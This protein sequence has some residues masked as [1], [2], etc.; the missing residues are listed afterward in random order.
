[1]ENYYFTLRSRNT[2]VGKMPVT[3]SPRQTCP[4]D[5]IFRKNG[6][7]ADAGPLALLWDKITHGKAGKAFKAMLK[8]IESLKPDQLWRHNQAGDLPSNGKQVNKTKLR[9]LVKANSGKRG[10]TFTHFDVTKN[11]HNRQA[12]KEANENGFVINLSGNDTTHAEKLADTRI[13]PVVTVLPLEYQKNESETY[14]EYRARLKT[15]PN[16]TP[17]GRIITVCPATYLEK[18][19][20]KSCR[21]CANAKRKTIVG[22]PAHGASK[23]KASNIARGDYNA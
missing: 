22:F 15:L 2:K 9:Q 10:F 14:T 3:T 23:V 7:Y 20:C 5:C 17:K 16:K 12:I 8:D 6:C 19:N 21:L 13:A 1:M 4:S 18:V 11:T